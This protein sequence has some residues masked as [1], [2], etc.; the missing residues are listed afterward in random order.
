MLR[1]ID[2]LYLRFRD[3]VGNIAEKNEINSSGCGNKLHDFKTC[4]CKTRVRFL[5][6]VRDS[7]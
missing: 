4:N 2:A 1:N 3:H 7:S 6:V 5:L